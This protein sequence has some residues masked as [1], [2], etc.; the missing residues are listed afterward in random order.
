MVA[1]PPP[2][3]VS[4]PLMVT[5]PFIV[6]CAAVIVAVAA[7][8]VAAPGVATVTAWLAESRE[9][10]TA[11]SSVRSCA[12]VV[13]TANGDAR[14]ADALAARVWRLPQHL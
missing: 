13:L 8:T 12:A 10:A 3:W 2:V 14:F 1:A 11:P 6:I 7:V 5:L 4:V 9:M